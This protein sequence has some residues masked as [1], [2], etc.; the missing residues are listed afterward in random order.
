MVNRREPTEITAGDNLAFTRTLPD[1][2]ASQGWILK[3][4]LR[5]GADPITFT[6]TPSGDDHVIAVD[7]ATTALWLPADYEAVGFAE[8]GAQRTAFYISHL[9]VLVNAE[10][11]DPAELLTHAQKMIASLEGQLEKMAQDDIIDSSVEGTQIR[12]EARKEI[13]QLRAKY[14]REREAEVARDNARNGRPTGR[15]IKPQINVMFPGRSRGITE[16]QG[17]NLT[18]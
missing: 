3:Y 4:V 8:N 16:F 5:G 18:P 14:K 15:R 2:P 9:T 11:K 7:A 6:S 17:G 13:F 12:R 10:V 1:Y